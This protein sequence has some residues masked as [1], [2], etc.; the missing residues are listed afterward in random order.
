EPDRI[1]DDGAPVALGLRHPDGRY[2]ERTLVPRLMDPV[3]PWRASWARHDVMV[4]SLEQFD[5][6]LGAW[7][8]A[9]LAAA[10]AG[11][12]VILDLRGNSGGR[13]VEAQN[14]LSCFLPEGRDWA[15]RTDRS[16]GSATLTVAP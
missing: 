9:M 5:E 8:G 2:E 15:S 12:K 14:V 1:L 7:V 3:D 16:G 6:G 11:T 4:L 13:I 10:P